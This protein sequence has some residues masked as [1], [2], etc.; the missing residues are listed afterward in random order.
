MVPHPR[1]RFLVFSIMVPWESEAVALPGTRSP[2]YPAAAS[3]RGASAKVMLQFVINTDRRAD[4]A[5]IRSL[6][7]TSRPPLSG[8]PAELYKTFVESARRAIHNARFKP[9]M[10]GGCPVRVIALQP[11]HFGMTEPSLR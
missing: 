5:T 11:Y 9:A 2:I 7:L 1:A 6:W 10:I 4:T 8:E 3:E